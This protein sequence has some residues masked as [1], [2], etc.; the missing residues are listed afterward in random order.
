MKSSGIFEH[1]IIGH[2]ADVT[3]RTFLAQAAGAALALVSSRLARP[4]GL[5][6]VRPEELPALLHR[7]LASDSPEVY[8]F[9][10]RA[11]ADC[12]LGKIRPPAPPLEHA[13]LVPGGGYYAQ[14][15]WDTMFVADLLAILPGQQ[16]LLRG[17]FQNYWDYQRRWDDWTP[18]YRHGMIANFIA[19]YGGSKERD[20]ITWRT[21]PA[22]SQAPLLAWGME[23]VFRRNGDKELLRAGLAPLEAFHDWYWRERDLT[24][25]GLVG[26]GAYSG[27]TQEAR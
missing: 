3:R 1:G 24:G 22:Y 19:P 7:L 11:Y 16:D 14:W 8:R 21:F 9:A 12:V 5:S 10:E 27:V 18:P 25:V 20:G 13:W 2:S 15:L 23:R 26:V 4:Q 6:P 17:V